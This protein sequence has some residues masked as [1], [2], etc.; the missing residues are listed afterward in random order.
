MTSSRFPGLLG[1]GRIS[2]S[3]SCSWQSIII[4]IRHAFSP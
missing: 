2:G 3:S 1:S 4:G